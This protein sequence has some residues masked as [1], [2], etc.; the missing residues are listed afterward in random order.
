MKVQKGWKMN[1][2]NKLII[3]I[4]VL[5]VMIVGSVLLYNQMR[6]SYDL[7]QEEVLEANEKEAEEEQEESQ[8]ENKEENKEEESEEVMKAADFTVTDKDGNEVTLSSLFGKPVVLNFWASWCSPCQQEMPDFQA[9]Y[10][11]QGEE[12]LFMMVNLTDGMRE[13]KDKADAFIAESGFTFPIYYD[14]AQD[15]A[16]VYGINSI[17]TTFFINAEGEVKT[18][19]PGM[20]T[21]EALQQGINMIKE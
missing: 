18:Y 15:A 10:E 14:T 21:K 7:K 3:G 1:N 2:K 11:E 13:T 8:E 4:V 17:P 19:Y 20:M 6:K 9:V 16:I 5:A 12:V